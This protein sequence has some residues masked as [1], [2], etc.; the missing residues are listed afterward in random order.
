MAHCTLEP[1]D[2]KKTVV[3]EQDWLKPFR[4]LRVVG[5]INPTVEER[6]SLSIARRSFVL[7]SL[8]RT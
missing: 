4:P 7:S 3:D 1:C 8:P 5:M 6:H 2:K